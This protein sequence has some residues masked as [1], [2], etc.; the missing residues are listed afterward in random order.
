MSQ[1]LVLC[2]RSD[3]GLTL[4]MSAFKL[5][6]VTN[7]Q[8]LTLNYQQLDMHVVVETKCLK[9]LHFY[10]HRLSLINF[11]RRLQQQLRRQGFHQQQN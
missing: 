8:S 4:K 6:M 9:M 5:F 1:A 2:L 7:I 3:E 11:K 10:A